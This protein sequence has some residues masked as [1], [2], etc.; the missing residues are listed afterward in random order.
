[1]AP[2]PPFGDFVLASGIPYAPLALVRALSQ[3][4]GIR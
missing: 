2:E 3:E 1:M 4:D